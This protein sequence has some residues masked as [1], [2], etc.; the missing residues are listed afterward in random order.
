[1][2]LKTEDRA[3]V[4]ALMREVGQAA[5][6]AA[7]DLALAPTNAKNEALTRAAAAMRA[8]TEQLLAANAEDVKAAAAAGTSPAFIDRLTLT[9]ARVAAMA[10]GLDEIAALADPVGAVIASWQRPNGL[11]I[12]RVRVPLGVIGIIYESR[13]NV[14]ADAG[15][16]C[17]KSGNAAILRG[18]SDSHRSSRAIHACLLEGMRAAGL[19]EADDAD[20]AWPH[21]SA[22]L[23]V[24][25]VWLGLGFALTL[26]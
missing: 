14:T 15:G 16:L 24:Q 13:P 25:V 11:A 23:A 4:A 6:A 7:Q 3:D 8:R 19:P 21:R 9:P 18:G 5:R 10:Q 12:E 1:M 20:G 2:Q 22:D 26:T 17:L